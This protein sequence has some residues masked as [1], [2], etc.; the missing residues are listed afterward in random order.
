MTSLM[1]ST[2]HLM[3]NINASQTFPKKEL[4]ILLNSLFEANITLIDTKARKT[5]SKKPNYR[6]LSFLNVD[7]RILKKIIGNQIQQH[8]TCIIQHE[9]MGF[10]WECKD[11]SIYEYS[12]K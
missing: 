1:N 5:H 12:S 7:A 2:T 9:Q 4:E 3:K 8:I 11:D 10:F 6:P